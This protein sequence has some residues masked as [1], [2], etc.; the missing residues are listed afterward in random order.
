MH[1]HDLNP[2]AFMS[3]VFSEP[4]RAV[5]SPG[6][7]RARMPPIVE[8]ARLARRAEGG[9]RPAGVAV[10]MAADA[11]A[12]A[13]ATD[14]VIE[15][16]E[17]VSWL[18]Q[19]FPLQLHGN[20][21]LAL[22][23]GQRLID[24]GYLAPVRP[25]PVRHSLSAR[26]V[27]KIKG[28]VGGNAAGARTGHPAL[29]N[30]GDVFYRWLGAIGDQCAPR[31][32]RAVSGPPAFATVEVEVVDCLSLDGEQLTFK[33][34]LRQQ[35][36]SAEAGLTVG[37]LVS[38]ALR[39]MTGD[40]DK[41][42]AL[43]L[44]M[45]S[46]NNLFAVNV[47]ADPVPDASY[48]EGA[49]NVIARAVRRDARA[50]AQRGRGCGSG[51]RE[52]DAATADT[53]RDA[54]EGA[55][56]QPSLPATQGPPA[57]AA[58]PDRADGRSR[59]GTEAALAA[60]RQPAS[61][62]GKRIDIDGIGRAEV[63]GL[64]QKLGKSTLHQVRLPG[65][66]S[67]VRDVQL[68]K[69]RGG[70]GLKFY[71]LEDGDES[72]RYL[73]G[74]DDAGGGG[75]DQAQERRGVP[76]WYRSD[77]WSD[78]A[79]SEYKVRMGPRYKKAGRKEPSLA[80]FYEVVGAEHVS[81]SCV[82]CTAQLPPDGQ[83]V[84]HVAQQGLRLPSAPNPAECGLLP[85]LLVINFQLPYKAPL[86]KG[87]VNADRG[88]CFV[89]ILR[90]KEATREQVCAPRSQWSNALRLL[91]DWLQRAPTDAKVSAQFKMIAFALNSKALGV[92][93]MLEGYNGKP[94]LIKN[95][96]F[97]KGPNY[98]E[99][100]IN[101]HTWNMLTRKTLKSFQRK[102]R[103]T[104]VKVGFVIEGTADDELPEQLLACCM[105]H[106]CNFSSTGYK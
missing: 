34:P 55:Q 101:I 50:A 69:T 57:P 13:A 12:D 85:P 2:N 76:N 80:S 3:H 20:A 1:G 11:A 16:R 84:S 81:R 72:G 64:K 73:E 8:V 86:A 46:T 23:N 37:W 35:H 93:S 103:E 67:E 30:R 45:A 27:D 6:V 44:S 99:F 82:F 100:D 26:A 51:S 63:V 62:V 90:I 53:E 59:S 77:T 95:G 68:R 56:A 40:G 21:R 9:V 60:R 54:R 41:E 14:T 88:G 79:A 10:A 52:G 87:D 7:A 25:A 42:T 24:D 91:V 15:G 97:Y 65:G 36:G 83:C 49:F 19:S 29:Q 28:M 32:S 5:S 22:A 58:Q 18:L 70:E 98:V 75:D 43:A 92:P 17:L 31:L 4:S 66:G 89:Y 33:L 106:N 94:V 47:Q 102:L 38:E 105:V 71:V 78:I 74:E 61:L 39:R 104:V 48:S 96:V